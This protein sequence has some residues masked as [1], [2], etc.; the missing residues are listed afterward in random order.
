MKRNSLFLLILICSSVYFIATSSSNGRATAANAGNTGAPSESQ[1][2]GNCHNGGAYGAVNLSIQVFIQGTTTPV[3]SY[4][5]GNTYDVRVTVQNSTG[6]PAGYGFQLTCLTTPGNSPLAGYTN[7]ATNVKQKTVLV[8]AVA[9]RTYVEHNGVLPNNQFNFSWTAPA[10]GTGSVRMYSAGNAV[11]GTGGTGSDNGGSTSL[12]LTEAQQLSAS[13]SSSNPTCAGGSN[14]SININIAS[15][16]A[17]YTFLWNDGNAQEDRTNLTAGN[18]S[19]S[20][21]DNAGQVQNLSFELEEPNQIEA[22]FAF[23]D[24]P[25]FGGTGW[26]SILGISGGNPPYTTSVSPQGDLDQLP[27]G[28]YIFTVTDES[29]C[30]SSF[31]FTISSPA[32]LEVEANVVDV[33]CAGASDG[34]ISLVSSGGVPPYNW[35][36]ADGDFDINRSFLFPGNYSLTITDDVGYSKDFSFTILEPQPLSVQTEIVPI[37]CFGEEAQIT[38]T[39]TGGN[40]SY[41]GVGIYN[42]PAGP[43]EAMI[44]DQRNC[45]EIVQLTIEQPEQIVI[46]YL[47]QPISC[48]GQTG[49]ISFTVSGGVQP[50]IQTFSDESIS[51]PGL[52]NY[53][54]I[55]A[56]NCS[57][58]IDVNV[59]A[60]DGFEINAAVENIACFNDCDGEIVLGVTGAQGVASFAWSDGVT[61]QERF[62]L[63]PGTYLVSITDENNCTISSS[64][65]ITQPEQLLLG[66][67]Q[68]IQSTATGVEISIPVSGGTEPYSYAWTTG[69]NT[70][71][72][73]IPYDENHNVIVS[74]ANG[75][76][77]TNDANFFFLNLE[78]SSLYSPKIYPNPASE[79]ITIENAALGSAVRIY[80]MTGRV[81]LNEITTSQQTQLDLIQLEQGNYIVKIIT[82][83]KEYTYRMNVR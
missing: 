45:S 59:P 18:Y 79:F 1:V 36:W 15:G 17:P 40:G 64:Y 47:T 37:S 23:N 43:F 78:E 22:Q 9:G 42:V 20:I 10:A 26:F 54:F 21:T 33:S 62:D 46:D 69:D 30:T 52:Y 16:N 28:D 5:P 32:D 53:V 77:V 6:N 63:C 74:D 67:F 71:T 41:A 3:T 13:G 29:N 81:V 44:V 51:S 66:N 83:R 73:L 35:Q 61:G 70:S 25:F 11:N 76:E 49:M 60:I 68:I 39:A 50:F 56:N 19:V 24:A 4:I 27:A 12:T 72:A 7:L 48:T 57:S 34:Q 65:T 2:C 80:D 14:G 82:D 8:G 31:E 75:C 58:S 55:D 38:V